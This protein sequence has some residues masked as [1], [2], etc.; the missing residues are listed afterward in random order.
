M[1]DGAMTDKTDDVVKPKTGIT[2]HNS[3]QQVHSDK[4]PK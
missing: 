1:D 2:K 3:V 4:F